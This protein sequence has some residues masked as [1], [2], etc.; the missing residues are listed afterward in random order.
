MSRL[1]LNVL[2]LLLIL[3]MGSLCYGQIQTVRINVKGVSPD[4]KAAGRFNTLSSGLPNVGK[5]QKVWLE[6]LALYTSGTNP[7]N[8]WIDTIITEDWTLTNPPGGFATIVHTDTTTYFIPDTT[9]EYKVDLTVTTSHGTGAT[10][11]YINSAYW[12]GVGNITGPATDPASCGFG[13]HDSK[14][15]DWEK[16]GHAGIFAYNVDSSDHYSGNCVYCHTVGYDALGTAVNGGWDDVATGLGF[17]IPSP[18]HPG[19]WDSIKTNFPT[20]A[21]VS[22]IQCENCH[23]PGSLHMGDKS[24]NKIAVS[25]SADVCG[26][27]HGRKFG[28]IKNYEWGSTAHAKAKGEPGEEEH[29]NSA[30][31]AQC[32]TAQGFVTENLGH[33]VT[34]APYP[35]V[36]SV[37]CTACHDPHSDANFAQL[38]VASLDDACDGC[39]KTRISG[40]GLHYSLQ[41]PMIAGVN[42]TPFTLGTSGIGT[43]GGLQFPGYQYR[44]SSHSSI[45]GTCVECHMATI[46][47]ADTLLLPGIPFSQ[48][49]GKLGG[50]TFR[51][52]F[53]NDTPDDATDDILNPVGCKECHGTVSL[54]F[55]EQSQDKIKAL[56]EELRVL[57][58]HATTG[59]TT[60]PLTHTSSLLSTVQK[61]AAYNYFFVVND[62]SYGVHNYEYASALLRS[63]IEMV[64]LGAGAA[65][66]ASI[67]DIPNDQGKQVQIVW[68]KF[69]AENYPDPVTN[70]LVLRQDSAGVAL[71]KTIVT[72]SS[73]RD[74][75]QKVGGGN[76]VLLSGSVWTKVGEFKALKQTIY[77]LVVPTLYDSTASGLVTTMFEVV[78]YTAT[79]VVYT[80]STMSGY[81]IDNLAPFAPAIAAQSGSSVVR[82]DMSVPT[83]TDFKY[84]AVY[85]GTTPDFIPSGTPLGTTAD[86]QYT[87][88]AVTVGATYY[89]KVSAFDFS[90]NESN[91][92]NEVSIMVTSV[93][94]ELGVPTEFALRQNHPNPFNPTTQIRYEL[95][96][97]EH[98]KISVY[99]ALGMLVTTLFDG[100]QSAGYQS[101]TWNG[102]DDAGMSVA[103]GIY[104]YKMEAGTTSFTR[105]MILMK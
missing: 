34:G 51:V 32:H 29:M 56:L 95:P 93:G 24:N 76:A 104:L 13:C 81:S 1:S 100:E 85:R 101:V 74:M 105:K 49:R 48:Y 7:I 18:Q 47:G 83:D 25:Y 3:A 11:V 40:R 33:N 97:A 102:K 89:Y 103:S 43:W 21:N 8:S 99:N 5:G 55:V 45:S 26:Q 31:C 10:T 87:D 70:Y 52:A 96:Q 58:P 88:A 90:G 6:A 75:L 69:P 12:V 71:G 57:L 9:G 62:G 68:N 61:A 94:D 86:V 80:S 36:Q 53:D 14:M 17:A 50:H 39:H 28:H 92:S 63:S 35:D 23:G 38:R 72:A 66:I 84:F 77:S 27:C 44:N 98:V 22:N 65:S 91:Y 73:Y 78:G 20:L 2:I 82:L 46:A 30:N 79:N 41:G 19:V 16:T 59:D 64:K 42:G 54:E 67:T 60:Q 4:L 37:T 15:A